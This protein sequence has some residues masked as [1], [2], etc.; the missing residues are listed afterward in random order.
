MVSERDIYASA[1]LL[2]KEHG[3]QAEKVAMENMVLLIQDDDVKGASVWMSIMSAINDLK[4][5][6]EQKHLH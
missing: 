4:L 1:K 3:A 5:R 6:S 2:M